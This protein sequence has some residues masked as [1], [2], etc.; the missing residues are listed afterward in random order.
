MKI[1][2]ILLTAVV[3]LPAAATANAQ[4]PH[5]GMGGPY[6]GMPA[7]Y[8]QPTPAPPM[9]GAAPMAPMD[10]MG[11]PMGPGG[12]PGAMPAD[13][14]GGGPPADYGQFYGDGGVPMDAGGGF[15]G[16]QGRPFFAGRGLYRQRTG[17]GY[18]Q[19]EALMWHRSDAFAQVLNVQT[20]DRATTPAGSISQFSQPFMRTS[21]PYFGYE[22]L[23]RLTIGYVLPNDV[24][25]EFQG[26][27]KDDFDARFDSYGNDNLD[28]VFFGGQ[29]LASLYTSAD[30]QFV[31]LSTAIHSYEINIVE[32][33]R[34]F[35]FMA[36][37][38][39]VEVADDLL[40]KTIK[41]GASNFAS[42]GTY[43]HLF[44]MHS[45][46]RSHI[47]WNLLGLD[48]GA[49]V[50]YFVNDAQ[51]HTLVTSTGVPGR[52]GG[53]LGGQND[54]MIAETRI[55]LT[56]RPSAWLNLK[57]GYD[58]MWI[59]NTALA[60]DQIDPVTLAGGNTTGFF[61]NAKG[62][63]FLHGPSFGMEMNW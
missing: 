48:L 57:A 13:S 19:A 39:Y 54:A 16:R 29:P 43:N 15:V 3:A 6:G 62:D 58:C 51:S 53:R 22:T 17:R 12:A 31:D 40:F 1:A 28:A 56:F 52:D 34:F 7:G 61:L 25:V 44:G 23:P 21:D 24:A 10:P 63:L 38:R 36:G 4:M 27:Y 60:A 55:A 26:F 46:V 37:V 30:A 20:P 45:G 11:A 47:D 50:G 49:K 2:R 41:N 9:N 14:F 32:T 35:N 5:P 8:F 18:F 33:T 59:V 42:I